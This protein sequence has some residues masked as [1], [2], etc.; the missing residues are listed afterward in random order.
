MNK[1]FALSFLLIFS[2]SLSAQKTQPGKTPIKKKPVQVAKKSFMKN[3]DDS[4]SYVIGMSMAN[5]A[6]QY[7]V[8]KLDTVMLCNAFADAMEGKPQVFN[9]AV[10]YQLFTQLTSGRK[11]GIQT[12][13]IVPTPN[14]P[15]ENFIDSISCAIGLDRANFLKQQGIEKMNLALISRGVNDVMSNKQVAINE[16]VANNVMN[17]LITNLQL[18]K[19]KPTI[20]EGKKFLIANKKKPGVKTTKSGLQYEIIKQGTGAKPTAV[21]T[22]VAHYRG[23]LLDGFEFDASYKRNEPLKL[24]LSQVIRGWTEGL[25]L[26]GIGSHY[27]FYIPY[28]L[29]YGP[30][31]NPPI[32]GGSM[33]IFELELL[34]IKRKK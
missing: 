26:M 2:I 6:K 16:V 20:Q 13:S 22:F 3:L 7:G 18:E 32:P 1:L 30:F 11:G 10:S 5:F 19:V 29:A 23:T 24:G 14:A 34:D 4:A 9:E 15:L 17:K 33:L 31:D 21:D 25:Q 27:K 28:E 8:R 12:D